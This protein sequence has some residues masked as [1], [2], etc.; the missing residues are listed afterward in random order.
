MLRERNHVE[1]LLVDR[2]TLPFGEEALDPRALEVHV[3]LLAGDV[4][5]AIN[6]REKRSVLSPSALKRRKIMKIENEIRFPIR[7]LHID[8][9]RTAVSSG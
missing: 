8:P 7:N 9:G 1:I 3:G 6:P 2:L 5:L 4:H